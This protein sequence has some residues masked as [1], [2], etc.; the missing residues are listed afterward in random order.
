[1]V[2]LL[3]GVYRRC[4][5]LKTLSL[6]FLPL[7]CGCYL[8]MF[9]LWFFAFPSL[10]FAHAAQSDAACETEKVASAWFAGWHADEGFDVND[11]PW[12]KYTEVT[13]AFA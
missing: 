1:M 10:Y 5:D 6:S 3:D 13:F 4:E 8:N 9:W 7:N 12:L 2:M 11:I